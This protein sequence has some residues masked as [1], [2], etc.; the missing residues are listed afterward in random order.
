M[1][2]LRLYGLVGMV[3][4][5]CGAGANAQRSLPAL[6]AD[7]ETF[8]KLPN[9]HVVHTTGHYYR[10]A[11]GRT[12]ED[13]G[14][15]SVIVNLK[16]HTVTMLNHV[17]KE[18]RVIRP[19]QELSKPEP[20]QDLTDHAKGVVEGHGVNKASG[21]GANGERHEVWTAED[22]GLVVFARTEAHGMTSTRTLR[23]ISLREPDHSMFDVPHGYKTVEMTDSGNGGKGM[24]GR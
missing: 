19:P 9:G 20:R 22:I 2:G 23:N 12:R 13:L 10:A 17:T 11:D 8:H 14:S 21:I 4:A 7:I 18:A 24:G 6:Q 16:S 15:G 3:L 5:M 1:R